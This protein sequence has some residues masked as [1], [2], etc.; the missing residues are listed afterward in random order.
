MKDENGRGVIRLHDKTTHGGEVITAS[1]DLT[2]LGVLVALKDDLTWC[3]KCGGQ[4][5]IIPQSSTRN[6]HGTPIAFHDDPTECGA[7]LI[8]SLE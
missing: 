8:S 1:D 7:R 2:A 4:F 3:P 5:R 6:H